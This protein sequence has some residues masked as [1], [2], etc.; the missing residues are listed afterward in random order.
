M[1][2]PP[3]TPSAGGLQRG[4]IERAPVDVPIR[5]EDPDRLALDDERHDGENPGPEG[6]DLVIGRLEAKPVRY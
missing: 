3:E 5:R 4:R 1:P 6:L 2:A